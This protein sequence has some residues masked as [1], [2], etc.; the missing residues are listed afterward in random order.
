[1]VNLTQIQNI[2]GF[3]DM[4]NVANSLTNNLFW[5]VIILSIFIIMLLKMLPKYDASSAI[6]A[7]SFVCL[8]LCLPLVALNW[9]NV[10]Y[11]IIFILLL[12]TSL[13]IIKINN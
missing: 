1:M 4:G 2:H 6:A 5:L 13:I 9:I 8:I 10:I 3:Y 11:A 12:A 7:S